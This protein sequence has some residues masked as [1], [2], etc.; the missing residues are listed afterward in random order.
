MKNL[1]Q[2]IHYLNSHKHKIVDC[3]ISESNV[4]RLF[5]KFKIES[6]FFK[7]NYGFSILDYFIN[8]ISDERKIGDC[9]NVK[10]FIF[11]LVSSNIKAHEIFAICINL[12]KN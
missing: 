12:R 4:V 8:A 1:K 11:F 2:I 6:V 10:Q 5:D 9:P 3:W 7:N